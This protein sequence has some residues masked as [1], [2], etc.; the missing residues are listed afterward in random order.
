MICGMKSSLFVLAVVGLA[1]CA[2]VAAGPESGVPVHATL[3]DG[4]G[5]TV[6]DLDFI[7]IAGGTRF[8]I[9]VNGLSPGPHGMHF[10]ETG[11]CEGPDFKSAGAHFRLA[12]QKHGAHW[13]DLPNLQ[14][15]KD[16]QASLEFSTSTVTLTPGE[17]SLLK[18]GGT[19][20]MIHAAADDGV[21]DPS[22]NSGDRVACAVIS[23]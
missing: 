16:G 12:S 7:E 4:M 23:K 13:G 3:I 6:G 22:G 20:L 15:G 9:R 21:T 11:K 19:S 8:T 14:V 5:K 1:G 2:T 17:R 10:H 18:E